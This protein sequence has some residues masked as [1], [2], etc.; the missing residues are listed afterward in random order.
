MQVTENWAGLGRRIGASD[1][2][3]GGA[4]VGG[5]LQVTENWVGPGYKESCKVFSVHSVSI[6][7]LSCQFNA[8]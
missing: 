5:K 1:R 4:W 3:L 8:R 2:K 6:K 7:L